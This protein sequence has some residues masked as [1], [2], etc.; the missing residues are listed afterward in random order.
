MLGWGHSERFD[1]LDMD[2]EKQRYNLVESG[3]VPFSVGCQI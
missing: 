1:G 2:H 3:A